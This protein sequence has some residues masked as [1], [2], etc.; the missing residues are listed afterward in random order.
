[1]QELYYYAGSSGNDF[2]KDVKDSAE[3]VSEQRDESGIGVFKLKPYLNRLPK[4]EI[5]GKIS[6]FLNGIGYG[7]D[8]YC[9]EVGDELRKTTSKPINYT[10]IAL[11]GLLFDYKPTN[12]RVTVD[13][14][15]KEFRKVWIA[16]TMHG[17]FYGGGAMATPKQDRCG[18][19]RTLSTLIFFGT[20]RLKTLFLFPSIYKGTHVKYT[21]YCIELSGKDIT[22]SFDRPVALQVDGETVLGITEY[23]AYC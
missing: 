13:G 3:F 22:V 21:K 7:L 20:G 11:K 17:R 8:G 23:H 19:E 4:I 12:A 14:V 5:R 6:Y 9:C 16:P 1:M 15:T 10:G 2:Y 18:K